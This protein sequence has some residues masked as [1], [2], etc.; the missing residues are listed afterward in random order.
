MRTWIFIRAILLIGTIAMSALPSWAQDEAD[1]AAGYEMQPPRVVLTGIGF[2]QVVT[3]NAIPDDAL[4]L[5][6][7]GESYTVPPDAF[8]RA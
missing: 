1:A 3:A 4:T 6:V 2:D 5:D 8:S 7:A